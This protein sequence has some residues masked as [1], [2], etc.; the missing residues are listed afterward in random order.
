MVVVG[1]CHLWSCGVSIEFVSLGASFRGFSVNDERLTR[2]ADR[3][4]NAQRKCGDM[5]A[6]ECPRSG[7]S[8]KSFVLLLRIFFSRQI[9][10][11]LC[12]SWV[13][14]D[15]QEIRVAH[16]VALLLISLG[17]PRIIFFDRSWIDF[18]GN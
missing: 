13:R 8:A 9:N 15:S 6:L 2:Q 16:A 14:S 12:S 11:N 1:V 7:G 4:T 10:W 17:R 5:N 3:D 18:R